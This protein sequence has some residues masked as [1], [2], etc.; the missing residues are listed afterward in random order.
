MKYICR[1]LIAPGERRTKGHA[2][3]IHTTRSRTSEFGV[4]YHE[5]GF[6][7]ITE[8]FTDD[9]GG[10]ERKQIKTKSSDTV[11]QMGI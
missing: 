5:E 6:Q 9:H 7:Q 3:D 4:V 2:K 1:V 10:G 8:N 11:F